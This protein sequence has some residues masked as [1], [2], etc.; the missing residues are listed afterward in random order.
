MCVHLN[1]F[2]SYEEYLEKVINEKYKR[3]NIVEQL[4]FT[5][6]LFY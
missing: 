5:R 2:N 3:L 1:Y 4:K 6:L